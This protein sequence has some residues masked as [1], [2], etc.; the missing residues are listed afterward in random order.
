MDLTQKKENGNVIVFDWGGSN[1]NISVLTLEEGL[2]DVISMNGISHLGGEDFDNRLVDYCINKFKSE[3]SKDINIIENPKAFQRIKLACEKAKII[4]STSTKANVDIDNII[5]EEDLNVVIT[6]DKFEELCI[7][8][9]RKCLPLLENSLKEAKLN[10]KEIDEIIL[11]GGSTRIPK[12]QDLIQEFFEGKELNKSINQH[13]AVACG[14]A[15]EAAVM[16][17]VKHE[18]IEKIILMDVT[19]FSLGIEGTGGTMNII[20]PRNFTISSKKTQIFTTEQDD[21][22]YFTVKIFNF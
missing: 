13:E 20:F 14:A 10:K 2:Y 3:T 1:I 6:R 7:D 11:V 8:L 5:G 15:I 21:Q 4:L 19:P 16:T 18:N 17:N 12:I 9:F 22:V